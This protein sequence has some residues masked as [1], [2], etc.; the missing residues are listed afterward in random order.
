[1]RIPYFLKR[2]FLFLD[3]MMACRNGLKRTGRNR[4]FLLACFFMLSQA[5]S[6]YAQGSKLDS[7]KAVLAHA[8]DTAKVNVLNEISRQ[9][10]LEGNIDSSLSYGTQALSLGKS[11]DWNKGVA[12]AHSNIGN[13]YNTQG[14]YIEALKS[15]VASLKARLAANDREGLAACY[16]NLGNVYD[17]L[18]N[19]EEALKSHFIS[20]EIRKEFGNKKGIANSYNNIGNIYQGLGN[21]PEALRNHLASL[22][23]NEEL[24]NKPGIASSYNNIGNVYTRQQ[25]YKEALNYFFAAL[26]I[27]QET[28]NRPSIAN[29]HMNLGS[30]YHGMMNYPEA[31]KN[32]QKAL[33]MYK[34][35]GMK[36]RMANVCINIGN[37]CWEQKNYREA[38]ENHES[39]LKIVTELN[40]KP[41]IAACYVNM[42]STH[43]KLGNHSKA[44]EYSKKGM[45]LAREMKA[46]GIVEFANKTLSDI[47]E[48]SGQYKEA[49]ESY[50]NYMAVQDSIENEENTRQ[51]VQAQMEY[52]FDKK[53]TATKLEQEK[54]DAI[55]E[56]NKKRQQV[57]TAAVSLGLLLVLVLAAVIFRSL[58]QNQKK[59]KIISEQKH[60]VEEKHKEITDSINYAERIQ[61][62]FLATKDALEQNL[63]NYFVFFQP[64]DVVSGDFYWVS[65]LNNGQFV[66][67]TADSTGHGVPG[68]IMSL[69]NITSLEKAVEHHTETDDILSH[70]RRT[71]IDRLKKDGSAEGGKDGM[72]C[73]LLRFD[74]LKNTMQCSLANNPVWIIRNNELIEIKP[75]RFP[76]GKHQRD[77]EPFTQ[78]EITLQ[79]G[80]MIYTLTDGYPDQF[81]GPKGKKFKHKPL[82][83]LLMSITALPMAEQG[84]KL[85]TV[86]DEWKGNLEQI[87]DVCIIGI[88][89]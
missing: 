49:L 77:E 22:K 74:F 42:G 71:I 4:L 84:Q 44:V 88:R 64:K 73:S 56:A 5:N 66:L 25:N 18:G 52:E 13:I 20:L 75:D 58:R 16:N 53:E 87:D 39:A 33:E 29:L 86:F 67:A 40:D 68:A 79:K 3:P 2:I 83:E 23:I 65:T 48:E 82:Q 41:G 15:H 24:G 69:L 76:V 21:Y 17:N 26:K 38:L 12:N 80:D 9:L 63:N 10:L 45:L 35:L 43:N 1:M 78:H 61:R 7:L 70:T 55:T 72:D 46:L 28:S 62:S 31:L 54:K 81:G 8:K 59:N 19:N 51:T 47:Y 34:E 11:Q 27:R 57:V 6:F 14:R 85:K 36:S 89:I 60:I 37:V 30:V 32:Y 50:R